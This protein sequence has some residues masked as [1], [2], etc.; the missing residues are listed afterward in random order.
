[1]PMKA[2]GNILIAV[3]ARNL[4]DLVEACGNPSVV[5]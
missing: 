2:L 4:R 5:R 1:M 3:Q